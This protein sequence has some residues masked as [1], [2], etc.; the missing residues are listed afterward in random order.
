VNKKDQTGVMLSSLFMKDNGLARK[1]ARR[2]KDD[3]TTTKITFDHWETVVDFGKCLDC[4]GVLAFRPG[5]YGGNFHIC[6]ETGCGWYISYEVA[7]ACGHQRK[8]G[9]KK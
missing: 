1:N 5:P 7:L 4:G 8:I 6:Q 3:G 2:R 9:L